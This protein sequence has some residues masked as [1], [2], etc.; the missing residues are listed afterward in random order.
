MDVW[1]EMQNLTR[2]VISRAAF[3]SS[4][5]EGRRIF[6]LQDELVEHIV[7]ALP[8]TVLPFNWYLPTENNKRMKQIAREVRTLIM[9]I[10]AK[11]EKAIQ[12]GETAKDDLPGLLLEHSNVK[13]KEQKGTS[14]SSPGMTTDEVIEECKTFYFTGQE[15]TSVLLTWTLVVLSMHSESQEK[16]RDEVLQRFGKQKPDFD[17]LSRLKIVT[18]I[19]YEV[20]RLYPPAVMLTRHAYKIMQLGNLTI[21]PG[22]CFY[23]CQYYSYTMTVKYGALMQLSSN[24]HGLLK[25]SQRQQ[26]MVS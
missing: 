3:G 21:P 11:R 17:G 18:M 1:P 22:A 4:Y 15:T 8:T 13:E 2:D 25:V 24:Q 5:Q 10:I 14:D 26:G 12:N 7:N 6:Q 20:L 9:N 19:L 23:A 16:A